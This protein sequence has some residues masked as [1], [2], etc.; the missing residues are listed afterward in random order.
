MKKTKTLPE[1]ALFSIRHNSNAGI[2]CNGCN[3]YFY[4]SITDEGTSA[5]KVFRHPN[6]DRIR[7]HY[8]KYIP[9][10]HIRPEVFVLVNKNINKVV[11]PCCF[12]KRMSIVIN[13]PFDKVA[14]LESLD[15]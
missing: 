12:R 1:L 7:R 8:P 14:L 4:V 11:C 9:F 15:A 10:L 5:Y 6:E 13:G 2:R 3:K